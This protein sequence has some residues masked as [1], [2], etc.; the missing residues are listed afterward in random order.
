MMTDQEKIPVIVGVGQYN[1]RPEKPDDG[2]DSLGLME[3]A[4]RIANENAGGGWLSSIESLATVRQISYPD[5]ENIDQL[6]ADRLGAGPRHLETTKMP[7]GDSPI[8]LLNEAANRIGS[9]EVKVAAIVGGEALRTAANEAR[10]RAPS[11]QNFNAVRERTLRMAPPFRR[12]YGLI[13]PIDIYPLYENACRSSYG[14]SLEE[15]QRESGEI[16]SRF[17]EVAK[18]NNG[19][20]IRNGASV[21]DIVSP[22]PSNRPIAHPYTKFLV[23]NSSVNQGAGYLVTSLAEARRRNV[24]ESRLIY[25]GLGAAAHEDSE[26]LHRDTYDRSPSM[27]ISIQKTLELNKLKVDDIDFVEL[28]SC[29]PCVPKMARRELNWP[30]DKPATVHGGLTFGGGPIGNYMAHAVAC[31]VEKLREGGKFG[32][33]FGNGGLATSNHTIV[34]SK[35]PI[36]AA[37][38]PQNFDFQKEADAAREALP[39]IEEAYEGNATLETYTV[40]YDRDGSSKGGVVVARTPAGS[41]TLAKVPAGDANAVE[42]L[43][44]GEK[45][46]V[47]MLG[48]I[49][50]N[51][52]GDNI[53]KF[54]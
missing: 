33:L 2:L 19:A 42:V 36:E 22:G 52:A 25:I 43:T 1:D 20:W 4:L 53:W 41:R 49:Q 45:D 30:L 31:M 51:D 29:F 8:L 27:G 26:P 37:Q 16:W 13:S 38:F 47:G 18:N 39:P 32:L 10:K 5:I 28:Y 11:D 40:Y 15:G 17:A 3:N 24:D 35:A 46:P 9:G 54:Q 12:R 14:Q 23:A 44:S 48:A 7:S 6:L 34:L 50:R 21:E